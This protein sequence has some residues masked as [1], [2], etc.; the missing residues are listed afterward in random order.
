[1]VHGHNGNIGTLSKARHIHTHLRDVRHGNSRVSVRV[2]AVIRVVR[3]GQ[4][5]KADTVAQ[6]DTARV[7]F[8]EVCS[9]TRNGNTLLPEAGERQ[10]HAFGTSVPGVVICG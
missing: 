7:R 6:Q 1:M 8:V 4:K 10:F 9:G 2:V 3:V 5:T